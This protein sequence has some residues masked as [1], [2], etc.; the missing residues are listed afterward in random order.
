MIEGYS[1]LVQVCFTI[2]IEW[3]RSILYICTLFFVHSNNCVN[4]LPPLDTCFAIAMKDFAGKWKFRHSLCRQEGS[5]ELFF[6]YLT[7]I[8]LLYDWIDMCWKK[9]TLL[10]W[11]L[12]ALGSATVFCFKGYKA[13]ILFPHTY[14]SSQILS[15]WFIPMLS[16]AKC[17]RD[18]F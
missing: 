6:L 11:G 18:H 16:P 10:T 8:W 15:V 17:F 1:P 9:G 14:S 2:V 3:L 5:S 7:N 4:R 13:S 12:T